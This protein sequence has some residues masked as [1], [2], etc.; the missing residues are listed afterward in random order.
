MNTATNSLANVLEMINKFAKDRQYFRENQK[1]IIKEDLQQDIVLHRYSDL[2]SYSS[3]TF[4]HFTLISYK[5]KT[6][7]LIP[8]NEYY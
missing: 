1:N 3:V 7:L 5:N 6:L 4:Y 8:R 2:K